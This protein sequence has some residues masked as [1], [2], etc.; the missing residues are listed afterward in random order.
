MHARIEIDMIAS[1]K[2]NRA[3]RPPSVDEYLSA[4]A[5]TPALRA[6]RR[7]FVAVGL[8]ITAEQAARLDTPTPWGAALVR[9][10]KGKAWHRHGAPRRHSNASSG[11]ST[12]SSS[13]ATASSHNGGS[14]VSVGADAGSARP[15][16]YIAA[17]LVDFLLC[18]DASW[19]MGW[20]GST[21]TR[22]L[23]Q[24]RELTHGEGWYQLCP[25]LSAPHPR[26]AYVH[27][28]LAHAGCLDGGAA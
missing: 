24:I 1:W 13:S 2:A 11:G 15:P 19:L 16:A 9:S 17:A 10:T 28:V 12:R 7:V 4:L 25:P 23:A 3:G 20:P 18:R 6:T 27:E 8:A 26:V 5:A 14:V 21:F 22:A